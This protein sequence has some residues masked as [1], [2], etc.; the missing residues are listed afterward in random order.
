VITR[1][2]VACARG[3][4][5][6]TTLFTELGFDLKPREISP[7]R[8]AD[9]SFELASEWKLYQGWRKGQL[10]LLLLECDVRAARI[11]CTAFLLAY[12]RWNV[13]A[14]TVLICFDEDTLALHGFD[15]RGRLRRLEID[16]D[17]P[18]ADAI[19]R[20]N[21]LQQRPGLT[22]PQ[23]SL[24]F[25][26]AL[27]REN[28]TRRFFE[29]FRDAVGAVAVELQT[30]CAEPPDAIR[31]QALLILS[32]ILFL[33]FLQHKGWLDGKRHFLHDHLMATIQSGRSFFDDLLRP[34]FFGCL[35]TPVDIRDEAASSLG[36]IPY[37]NGG[38]F[39]PSAFERRYPRFILS[40]ELLKG[41]LDEVLERYA[42]CIDEGDEEGV[43]IDPE[44]LGKV[45][46]S[47]MAAEERLASGSFYTPREI[48]DTIAEEAIVNWCA[49]E[50]LLLRPVLLGESKPDPETAKAL[51]QRLQTIRVLD[52]ACG[53]G[54][55]LLAAAKVIERLTLRLGEIAGAPK[56]ENLRQQIIAQCLFGVDIKPEAVRLCELRLW[57]SIVSNSNATADT[58][59]PLPNLDRNI[60]QGNA[61]L[62]PLDFLGGNRSDIYHRWSYALRA[63]S[64][65]LERYRYSSPSERP[66]LCRA[67]RESDQALAVALLGA[68]VKADREDLERRVN[69]TPMLFGTPAPP[70]ECDLVRIRARLA[71][72][73][74]YLARVQEGVVD[75]FAFDFHFA[76][77]VAEHGFG[78]IVGNPPWVRSARIPAEL[79]RSL[80]DRFQL[81]GAG[82]SFDQSDLC[83]AFW[84]KAFTVV[85]DGGVVAMLLPSKI[86]TSAYGAALRK[87]VSRS[88]E[89]LSIRDWS[90]RSR[91]LFDADTY[92]L[93]LTVRKRLP[94]AGHRAEIHSGSTH[95]SIAQSD[96]GGDSGGISWQ[97]GDPEVTKIAHRI[98]NRHPTLDAVL[99]RK[100]LMG[101]KTGANERFF[102]PDAEP[103]NGGLFVPSLGVSI[104][105]SGVVRC[106][107]GRDVRR[108]KSTGGTWMLLPPSNGGRTAAWLGRVCDALEVTPESLRL[109]YVQP[110]H[111]AT[112]VVWKDVSRG[113]QAVVMPP[114][115]Q[116][117]GREFPVVPNQTLYLFEALS[118]QEAF[119]LSALLNSTIFNALAAAEADRAK[120]SHFRYFGRTVARICAP[121]KFSESP[122]IR[123]LAILARRAH[124]GA[125]V[126]PEIDA[127]VRRL[128]GLSRRD[129]ET[130]AAFL[131]KRLEVD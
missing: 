34:L 12:R 23:I 84:E 94:A 112:K 52:P 76:H 101:V 45:F 74:R 16:L 11:S 109:A 123:E 61:L 19:D 121:E 66:A 3:L 48:V 6:V 87:R 10:D 118:L 36:R 40:N 22:D 78:V 72:S 65:L 82:R 42:I 54:A 47:L 27:E 29:R 126:L 128:Y 124:R 93:A 24:Q 83:V 50:D 119:A 33:Y 113:L 7:P 56:H 9:L 31:G 20:L 122:N 117:L 125:G 57:L 60:L 108:W 44:M 130:L 116:V 43:H 127:V 98:R 49:G 26:Q 115:T 90:D 38:L 114:T 39:E 59:G 25:E 68:A 131:R 107:R 104:P 35:N 1:S 80:T 28:I 85:A 129:F 100:P 69:P 89:I 103:R 77:V 32:R 64:G 73:E 102:L 14:R 110:E 58:V 95:Y 18:T 92:P 67:I 86:A 4:A 97:I 17:A 41:V 96:M 15:S 75:F 13:L 91:D 99:S 81:F 63:R 37:L 8:T 88:A 21:V 105:A 79:R 111:F 106:V 62:G 53:S 55:F 30:Q 71:S 70:L 46:E 51:L 5:G 120:D 2:H